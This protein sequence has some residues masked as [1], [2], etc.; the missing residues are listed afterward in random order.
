M[1]KKRTRLNVY[2][3]LGASVHERIRAE[4]DVTPIIYK[5][6]QSGN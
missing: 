2:P 4:D 6:E 1:R 5:N 3:G